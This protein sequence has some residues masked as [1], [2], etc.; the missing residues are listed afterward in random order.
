[1]SGFERSKTA[2]ANEAINLVDH[3]SASAKRTAGALIGHFNRQTGQCD[4][5]VGRLATMLGID[6]ATVRRA[7]AELCSAGL[8]KKSSHGGK[9]HRAQYY[10]QWDR[11]EEI[12][13]D[14]QRR[15]KTGD[16]PGN[17]A[18]MRASTAQDCAVEPRNIAPQTL[19]RNPLRIVLRTVEFSAMADLSDKAGL[20]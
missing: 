8:F 10:P 3:I 16:P 7:T 6:P 17:R 12:V 5:S 11:F 2:I 1:M 13:A 20:V 4:P 9:S 14:W 19:L 15:M 18:E